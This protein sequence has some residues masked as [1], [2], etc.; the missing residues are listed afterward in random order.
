VLVC[1]LAQM[2]ITANRFAFNNRHG[3]NCYKHVCKLTPWRSEHGSVQRK[4]CLHIKT[5]VHTQ[6]TARMIMYIKWAEHIHPILHWPPI[7]N[8]IEWIHLYKV[9]TLVV[10]IR[11]TGSLAYLLPAVCS[12]ITTRYLRWPSHSS[13]PSRRN[14]RSGQTRRQP[15][16]GFGGR[17]QETPD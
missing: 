9:A 1:I 14:N 10:E 2:C 13:F 15:T 4:H 17:E 6:N 12:Y 5:T 16:F 3:I 11:L 8:H 7:N